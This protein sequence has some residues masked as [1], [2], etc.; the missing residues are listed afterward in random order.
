MKVHCLDVESD[1]SSGEAAAAGSA[2]KG[3]R[4]PVPG[5]R[6][7]VV[8]SAR[9]PDEFQGQELGYAL[10]QFELL[11]TEIVRLSGGALVAQEQR[12]W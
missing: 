6:C 3:I 5:L 8:E 7:V 9:D 2:V 1:G 4:L 10:S 11:R 12:L